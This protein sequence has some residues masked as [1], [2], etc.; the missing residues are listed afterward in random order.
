[1]QR[2]L[3]VKDMEL[4]ALA[5]RIG[6]SVRGR[7]G[8]MGQQCRRGRGGC[9]NGPS[10]SVIVLAANGFDPKICLSITARSQL[11]GHLPD[12]AFSTGREG[13]AS[14]PENRSLL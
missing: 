7:L 5:A 8:T 12:R 14:W 4:G 9:R 10:H 1:M 13:A 11:A 6:L 3:A 2:D